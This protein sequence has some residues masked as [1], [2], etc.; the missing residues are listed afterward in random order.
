[1][2]TTIKGLLE[3]V[4]PSLHEE[5]VA[6]EKIE[7]LKNV[8][9]KKLFSKKSFV[10]NDINTSID[11]KYLFHLSDRSFIPAYKSKECIE[12]CKKRN[13]YEFIDSLYYCTYEK[14]RYYGM[15]I[16][17]FW[18]DD[19]VYGFQGRRMDKKFFDTFSPND[20]FKIYNVFNVDTTKNVFITEAIIDSMM[21]DNSIA[22]LGSDLST[23]LQSLIPNRIWVLDNDY[24]GYTKAKKYLMKGESVVILPNDIKEKDLNDMSRNGLT[25]NQIYDIIKNNIFKGASG[26]TRINFKLMGKR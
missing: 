6:K 1:L 2:N 7:W 3:I 23:K 26:L 24:T 16:F 10:V 4:A 11:L 5:Y 19:K 9:E 20:Q 12:Y 25:R 21:I 8:N 14:S 22:M 18:K 15:L 13:I 17:P